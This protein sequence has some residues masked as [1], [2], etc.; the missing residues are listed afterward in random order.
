MPSNDKLLDTYN[1]RSNSDYRKYMTQ[2]AESVHS[3]N[4]KEY[5]AQFSK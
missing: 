5:K 2:N 1:I 4:E 3:Y